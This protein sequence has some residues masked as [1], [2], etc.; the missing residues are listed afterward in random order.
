MAFSKTLVYMFGL[1]LNRGLNKTNVFA[2]KPP[3]TQRAVLH[4]NC[5]TQKLFYTKTVLHKHH[6]LPWWPAEHAEG[7]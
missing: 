7:G 2:S 5:F 1:N 3:L 6:V 4:K